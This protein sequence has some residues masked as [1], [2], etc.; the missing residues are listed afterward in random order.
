MRRVVKICLILIAVFAM[1]MTVSAQGMNGEMDEWKKP[2]DDEGK[3]VK[4]FDKFN[5]AKEKYQEAMEKFR[6]AKNKAIQARFN[7][8]KNYLLRW[9]EMCERWMER[10]KVRVQ[11][12]NMNEEVKLRITER[13][14]NG[15]EKIDEVK[16]SIE[17]AQTIEELREAAKEAKKTWIEL[18]MDLRLS[19]YDYTLNAFYKILDKVEQ[20]RDRLEAAGI[21]VQEIN[22]K[23]DEIRGYLENAESALE[24][25]NVEVVKENLAKAKEGLREVFNEIKNSAKSYT[26][27]VTY[28][29]E[30]GE[31]FAKV[32]GTFR[33]D[34][35]V[36]ALI[37]G[38][39]NVTVNP[40]TSVV[41]DVTAGGERKIVVRGDV[42]V[43]G[44]GDFRIFAKGKG[45]LELTGEG[46]YRV[47]ESP[48]SSMSDE[49][50]FEGEETVTFGVIE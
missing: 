49:T 9:T 24:A 22:E 10:L 1:T 21:N 11:N 4:K 37:R 42:V 33:L 25:S 38:E 35:N 20:V 3:P 23:I 7:A 28:G 40:T 2:M 27:R 19:A 5:E 43:E 32:D 39:G 29:Y 44:N 36:T 46:Y 48:E 6:E 14:Q 47:K 15:L 18:K 17:N 50:T 31:I 26:G 16:K 41:T 12:S 13:I 8:S 34:G 30:S 45:E